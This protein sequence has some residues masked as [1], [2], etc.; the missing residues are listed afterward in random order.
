MLQIKKI[1]K[2]NG[3]VGISFVV[4]TSGIKQKYTEIVSVFFDAKNRVEQRLRLSRLALQVLRADPNAI[5]L[6][7]KG[8]EKTAVAD[9]HQ[10]NARQ[11]LPGHPPDIPA[12]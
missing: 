10:Y 5:S 2:E 3:E 12:A 8:R 9:V 4:Q 11:H 7:K 6:E 1:K